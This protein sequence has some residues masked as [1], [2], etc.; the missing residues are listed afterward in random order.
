M[1]SKMILITVILI[2]AFSILLPILIITNN[3]VV[4]ALMIT[5]GIALYHFT[6]RLVV[7]TVVDLIIKNKA[8]YNNVWFREKPF[9]RKLYRILHVRKWKKHIPTYSPEVFDTSNKTVED[10]IG[11]TCQ[12]EI[13]H[14]VIMLLSLLPIAFIPLLGGA[15]AII[16]TSALAMMIDLIFVLLQRY[17]R[18]RLVKIA[19]RFDKLNLTKNK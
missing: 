1:K 6:M 9:E 18:P 11:A 2:I 17:N 15:V 13:V 4:E 16:V 5:V 12:A 19:K 3:A 10:I 7:G 14:E 8:D